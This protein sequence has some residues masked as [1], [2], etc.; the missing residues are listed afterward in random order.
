MEN[1]Y[2]VIKVPCWH[3][4]VYSGKIMCGKEN[5]GGG[6]EGGKEEEREVDD[7]IFLLTAGTH[8]WTKEEEA[9]EVQKKKRRRRS[10]EPVRDMIDEVLFE[11]QTPLLDGVE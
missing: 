4:T 1:V 6:E 10:T 3:L 8:L 9:E 2:L 11:H 5:G 7:W